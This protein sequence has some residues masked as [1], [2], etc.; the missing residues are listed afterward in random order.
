MSVPVG[1]TERGP[2]RG[3]QQVARAGPGQAVL[4]PGWRSCWGSRGV[5]A[6]GLQPAGW[7]AGRLVVQGAGR[8]AGGGTWLWRVPLQHSRVREMA[9][10]MPRRA[11]I[12]A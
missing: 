12:A 5:R 1:W 11:K 4:D 10:G 7:P 2:A 8:P 6:P 9:V 3:S